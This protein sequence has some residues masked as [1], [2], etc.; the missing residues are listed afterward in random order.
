MNAQASVQGMSSEEAGR[1]LTQYGP[2]AVADVA[3]RPLRRL[4]GNFSA[5]VPWLLEATVLLELLLGKRIEATVIFALLVFNAALGFFQESRAQATLNALKS[6]LALTAAVLRDGSWKMLPVLQLVPGDQVKLSLGGVVAADVCI[7]SGA[8]LLDQS[9]LTG[10]SI[11][12]DAGVGV[13]AYAG[14]L[15]R[16]GEATARV[17]ATG[18]RTK[19]GRTADLIRGAHA[20]S[21]QQQA[22]FRVVRNLAACNGVLVVLMLAYAFAA[23]MPSSEMISLTLTAVLASIPVALPA[24][25]TLAAALGA[26]ALAKLGVL[27]T[28]LSAVDEAASMDVLCADKTGTLTRNRLDVTSL[29]PSAGFSVAQLLAFGALASSDGGLDPV[30]KAILERAARDSSSAALTRISFTPFD[31]ATKRAEATYCANGISQRVVKGA[32]SAVVLLVP[33]DAESAAAAH[34]LEARGYRVLAVAAGPAA[35]LRMAG[36]IA[37]SDPPRADA[38]A[39][40]AE[41]RQL[42]VSTVMVTGDAP[43]TAAIVAQAVGLAGA[44]CPPGKIPQ[45]ISPGE[46]GIFAG[47]LPEDKYRIVEAFQHEKHIVGMCGD[48]ANDAPAL[49]QAQIGIAVSSAT[50]V[51]KA[52]AGIVLTTPG[53]S[54]IVATVKEGRLIYQRILTYTINSITKKIVQVSFLAAGLIITGHAILTPMLMIIVMTIGDFLGMSLTTDRVRASPHPNSWQIGKLTL[55]GAVMGLGE[56]AYCTALFACGD[57]YW[58]LPLP[59]LQ[60]LAFVL[61]VFGNQATTY[62]NRERRHLWASF[63]GR[64]VLAASSA[65]IAIAAMLAMAGIAMRALPIGLILATLASAVVFALALDFVKVPLFRRLQVA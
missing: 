64:W 7:L 37:L 3:D 12:S 58:H 24:T 13:A 17:T 55:A 21:S 31:A 28:R 27:P 59:A 46:F 16:R 36:L 45:G 5:P 10:E 44:L 11:A 9:M 26:R 43:Q 56:L 38:Q 41:L 48:G 50:D 40:I 53:L 18:E 33:A 54:G 14:A 60:S 52:A 6:R 42:G 4:L 61:I 57:F 47:V 2:N 22:V 63:P 34:A 23:H 65:D 30:D 39:L 35:G 32:F 15:I 19:F 49:R 62:N 8:V 25:F 20:E 29:H 51:A 1:R